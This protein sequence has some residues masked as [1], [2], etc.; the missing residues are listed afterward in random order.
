CIRKGDQGFTRNDHL[1]EHRR[2]FHM[3]GIPKKR[4]RTSEGYRS[5][6]GWTKN[7]PGCPASN[8]SRRL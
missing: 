4:T 3:E 7:A 5:W 1:V 2:Q 6:C 8:A